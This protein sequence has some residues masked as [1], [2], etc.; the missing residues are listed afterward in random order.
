MNGVLHWVGA[1]SLCYCVNVALNAWKRFCWWS[2]H[3]PA[4]ETIPL[5]TVGSSPVSPHIVDV[6][7]PAELVAITHQLSQALERTLQLSWLAFGGN[8]VVALV[9]CFFWYTRASSSGILD[10]RRGDTESRPTFDGPPSPPSVAKSDYFSTGGA[11]SAA[12]SVISDSTDL[13]PTV[14]SLDDIA[15]YVPSRRTRRLP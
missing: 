13:P 2:E 15:S 6:Q 7:T 8:L 1:V 12:A 9:A 14:S 5:R 11:S 4:L 10:S 3:P